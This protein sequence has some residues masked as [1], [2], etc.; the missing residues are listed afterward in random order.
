EI[1]VRGE[2]LRVLLDPVAVLAHLAVRAAAAEQADVAVQEIAEPRRPGAD[3]EEHEAA[4]ED[5]DEQHEHP[6]RVRAK[7]GE[8]HRV[9]DDAGSAGRGA[10]TALDVARL[11]RCAAAVSSC[12]S[13]PPSSSSRE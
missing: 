10:G 7:L 3:T 6:L 13:V 8:E 4:G 2:V 1:L 12:H 9:L 5:D 11:A